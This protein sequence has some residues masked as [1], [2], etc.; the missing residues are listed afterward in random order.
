MSGPELQDNYLESPEK[1]G[2][3][4]H[5][6]TA[7]LR[8]TASPLT[9]TRAEEPNPSEGRFDR[10]ISDLVQKQPGPGWGASMPV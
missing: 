1:M 9:P 6:P 7:Q 5:S 2:T 10:E 8:A 3:L 4:L